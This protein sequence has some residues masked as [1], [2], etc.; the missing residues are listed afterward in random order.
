MR[1]DYSYRVA[2]PDDVDGILRVFAE[3]APEVPTRVYEFAKGDHTDTRQSI[4]RWVETGQSWVATDA[5]GTVVGYA[6]AEGNDKALSL[7]YLGVGKAAR[8][9][10]VCSSLV[11]KLKE[12]SAAITTDVRSDNKSSM[13]DIFEHLEFAKGDINQDRT[14]LHWKRPAT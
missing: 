5:T 2:K 14:K 9:Q 1:K 7:V 3:V 13:V 11:S 8:N 4:A 12:A 6:L 10:H